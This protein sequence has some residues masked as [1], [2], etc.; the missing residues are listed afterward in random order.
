MEIIIVIL[1]IFLYAYS[2]TF[3]LFLF[4]PINFFVYLF[5]DVYD[6]YKK[7]RFIPKKPF[8]NCY[9]GL[10]GSGKTLTMVHDVIDFYH[11]YNNKIVY[12]DR[13]NWFCNQKVLILSNVDLHTVPYKK[14]KSMTQIVMVRW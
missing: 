9:V 1:V 6:N 3:R 11:Q 4:H 7:Y 8:I 10:F 14:L 13:F 2:L 5:K 12:D